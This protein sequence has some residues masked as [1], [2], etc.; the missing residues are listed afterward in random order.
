MLIDSNDLVS[1]TDLARNTSQLLREVASGQRRFVIV[2]RN[3]LTAALIGIDDL[4]RLLDAENAD[5]NSGRAQRRGHRDTSEALVKAFDTNVVG[6]LDVVQRWDDHDAESDGMEIPLGATVEGEVVTLKF[7]NPN[8]NQPATHGLLSGRPG[9]GKSVALKTMILG[10]CAEFSP[11]RVRVMLIECHGGKS[12]Y[13]KLAPL[14][15]ITL[16]P[17]PPIAMVADFEPSAGGGSMDA[18]IA[19]LRDEVARRASAADDGR[20]D[21]E[22]NLVV[23]FEDYRA[24][25]HDKEFRALLSYLLKAGARLKIN[26]LLVSQG[27]PDELTRQ[28]GL[29]EWIAVFDTS[30]REDSRA[31]L[32][33]DA[34][35]GLPVGTALVRQPSD[36]QP[37]AVN[38][39]LI[40]GDESFE[41]TLI[42][43]IVAAAER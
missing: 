34:A 14:P 12:H 20:L 5:G 6:V 24:A 32:G 22:P 40:G 13:A 41:E 21:A 25:F 16:R 35:C 15:H 33:S 36:A 17:G 26:V 31:L 18:L 43:Q 23:V 4:R 28:K 19:E 37:T 11:K 42:Q 10:L 39:F 2:N 29:F 30:N 27:H 9:S 38:V 7:A 1:A 3:T 8:E